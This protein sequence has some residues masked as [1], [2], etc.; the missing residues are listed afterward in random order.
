M[1]V[2]ASVILTWPDSNVAPSH[3]G[4]PLHGVCMTCRMG[5]HTTHV[6]SPRSLFFDE[7]IMKKMEFL[8]EEGDRKTEL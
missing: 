7:N 6:K 5:E 3:D 8:I 1:I 4:A 2:M